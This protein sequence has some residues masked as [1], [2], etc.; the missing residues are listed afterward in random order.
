MDDYPL[1][2]LFW[3]MLWLFVWVM[4]FFLL[5]KVITDLFRDHGMNGWA[6]A[7]WLILV[8]LLPFIGVLIYLIVRGRSMAERDREQAKEQQEAFQQYVR[9]TAAPSASPAEELHKLSALKDKGDI[10]QEEFDRAKQ[11][12]LT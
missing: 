1:L 9:Q 10:T 8:L 5:F 4:W 12:L 11:K 3:T 7:G 2:E 6:K